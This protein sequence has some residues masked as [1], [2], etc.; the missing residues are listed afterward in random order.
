MPESLA[1]D[2]SPMYVFASLIF[3][4]SFFSPYIAA[5]IPFVAPYQ[6]LCDGDIENAVLL[7]RLFHVQEERRAEMEGD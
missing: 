1:C 3:T 6:G 2:S 5:S 7:T 4:F